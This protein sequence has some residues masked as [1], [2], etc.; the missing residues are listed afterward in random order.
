MFDATQSKADFNRT[1]N[2][3]AKQQQRGKS[4][5]SQLGVTESLIVKSENVSTCCCCQC[6][7]LR[8]EKKQ[9]S[10]QYQRSV[11]RDQHPNSRAVSIFTA[12][13]NAKQSDA[14]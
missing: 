1:K 9:I 13:S 7:E 14:K 2:M 11:L 10:H 4:V 6:Q 5:H 8:R 12:S 3:A